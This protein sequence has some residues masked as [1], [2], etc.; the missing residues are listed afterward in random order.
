MAIIVC[1]FWQTISDNIVFVMNM[2]FSYYTMNTCHILKKM[3]H[4]FSFMKQHHGKY[5]NDFDH[6]RVDIRIRK[7]WENWQYLLSYINHLS[8]M[9]FLQNPKEIDKVERKSLF[10][11]VKKLKIQWRMNDFNFVWRSWFWNLDF[12]PW[13]MWGDN[14]DTE[15]FINDKTADLHISK[16][17]CI[18]ALHLLPY[19]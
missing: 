19:R 13:I 4:L 8:I 12:D 11:N 10:P 14:L 17:I 16:L 1:T 5:S 7:C 18:W 2:H 3:I 15:T 6:L 9:F